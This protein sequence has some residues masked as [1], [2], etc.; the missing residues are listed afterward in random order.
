MESSASAKGTCDGTASPQVAAASRRSE[1]AEEHP[2]HGVVAGLLQDE[3]GPR[4]G[5]RDVAAEVRSVDRGP[6]ALRRL[7]GLVVGQPGEA[8]E[9]GGGVLEGRPAQPEE[10]L[11]VPALDVGLGGVDVDGEVE[12]VGEE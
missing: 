10:P 2:A 12:E 4:P 1:L 11:D 9:V 6:D 7:A 3:A 5:R 8:V